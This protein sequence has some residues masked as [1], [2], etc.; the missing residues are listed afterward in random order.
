MYI[1]KTGTTFPAT[2]SRF[3][4]FEQWTA[5]ALGEAVFETAVVDAAGGQ[6]LPTAGECAGV[7]ITGS[8]AMVT[9]ELPWSVGIESW[10]PSLIEASIPLLGICYGHQLLARAMGGRVGYLRHGQ[11]IG[12]VAI[13]RLTGCDGDILFKQLPSSFPA[14]VSHKQTVL[15]L[16]PGAVALAANAYEPHHAFRLGS[17]AWGVQFHP[18]YNAGIMRSYIEEQ[19]SDLERAGMDVNKLLNDVKETPLAEGIMKR[20]ACVVEERLAAQAVG[21]SLSHGAVGIKPLS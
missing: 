3:G 1:I 8:H 21:G 10:I 5:K 11:E 16:P 2:A 18:E 20:F 9:N 17:C 14:H 7:V 6:P 12:T 15:A 13:E 4:D 19:T